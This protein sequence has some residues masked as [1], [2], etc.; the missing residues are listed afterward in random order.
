M[1]RKVYNLR[2]NVNDKLS[3]VQTEAAARGIRMTG[4]TSRGRFEGLISGDYVVSGSQITVTISKW[5]FFLNESSLDKQLQS[6][7]ESN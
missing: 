7:L 2:G 5:P 6:F 3:R 4:N 1:F